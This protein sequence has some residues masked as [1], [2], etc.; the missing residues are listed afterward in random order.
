MNTISTINF[1]NLEEN[2]GTLETLDK[3]NRNL[4]AK[5]AIS[6]ETKAHEKSVQFLLNFELS[7]IK[8][9]IN[10]AKKD[11]EGLEREQ[12][13]L[14]QTHQELCMQVK[15]IRNYFCYVNSLQVDRKEEHLQNLR[16][17]LSAL[18]FTI[19]QKQEDPSRNHDSFTQ[20]A[21]N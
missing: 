12:K 2:T 3:A 9:Q 13:R 10:E 11:V 7:Q 17:E 4:A 18:D 6:E 16:G 20:L 5:L 15:L 21:K 14:A 1:G 8:K 19:E